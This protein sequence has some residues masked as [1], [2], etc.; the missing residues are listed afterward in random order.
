MGYRDP[1]WGMKQTSFCSYECQ[2]LMR[3][4]LMMTSKYKI[5]T[6]ENMKQDH[7]I[8]VLVVWGGGIMQDCQES[9]EAAD[10]KVSQVGRVRGIQ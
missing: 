6:V 3:V 7:M 5:G 2:I 1:Q 10:T 4:I 8:K 9:F